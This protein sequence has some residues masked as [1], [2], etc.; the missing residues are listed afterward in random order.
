MVKTPI[1]ACIGEAMIELSPDGDV[2]RAGVAG[3]AL[4]TAVYLKRAAGDALDVQFVS[5]LGVDPFSDRIA[6]FVA[7]ENIGTGRIAR[8]SGRLCG[9]YAIETDAAGERSF[10]FWRGQSAARTMFDDGFAAL[11]GVDVVF[12][13]AISLA[14]LPGDVRA[15]L[16]TWLGDFTGRVV[17][18]SN[19][20]PA[21]WAAGEA[22]QAIEAAWRVADVALPSLDDELAVFGEADEA[23]VLRRFAG[24]PA[25]TGAL[26]RG[27]LGPVG[28]GG[29]AAAGQAG[30]GRYPAVERVVDSTAAGDS[31]NG[32]FLAA[33]LGGASRQQ[34]MRQGHEMAAAVLGFRGAIC[35]APDGAGST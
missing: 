18:D 15:R 10:H 29:C 22:R 8:R 7:A 3:D 26:K 1:V 16:L 19:Y 24:Y 6:A 33:W 34:A 14:I 23:A 28:V 32:G 30:W 25:M 21:L 27:Q 20:R 13:S 2:F 35:P 9:L 4:N 17:F 12:L 11:D 5:A 31:F